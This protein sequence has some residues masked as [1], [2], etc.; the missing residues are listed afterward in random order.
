M[1]KQNLISRKEITVLVLA[2]GRGSRIGERD[3][4]LISVLGRPMLDHLLTRI[5]QQSKRILISANRNLEQYARYG[6]PLVR[7]TLEGFAGPLAGI[8]AGLSA[9]KTDY[10]LCVPVDAPMVCTDYLARMK[11]ALELSGGRACVAEFQGR[12]QPVFC[13]V[14]RDTLYELTRYLQAGE[15]S[16]HGWL[17]QIAALGVD[18]SDVPEQFVNL[19]RV[20]DQRRL[21]ALLRA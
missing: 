10:L 8:L 7:D 18:F 2:G 14:K 12:L 21:E 9:C 20:D 5:G 19:N 15:R 11:G 1:A 4:G 17:Q 16:V 6:Y 3:K 13:L